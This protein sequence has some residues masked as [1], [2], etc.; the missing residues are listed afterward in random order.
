MREPALR[1]LNARTAWFALLLLLALASAAIG[2]LFAL[3]YSQDLQWDEARLFLDG[4]NPYLLYFEPGRDRPDYII[5][6]HLGLTQ[7][8]SAVLLFAPIA[9]TSF[10]TARILW[11]LVNFAATPAF[12]LLSVRLFR[13]HRFGA[14][15]LAA[16][17]LL[18]VASMP[19]RI[20][21]G[22]GQYGL[23]A[24]TLFLAALHF[25]RER[26]L[27][28]ATL[29]S[30]LALV[31]Y[32]LVLPFFA[33][34]LD[35]K[36][37]TALVL[38]GAF[39]IHLLLTVAAGHLV[40][41]RP[42]VLIR[43]S[44]TIAA[45]I[46]EAGAYDLFA[47]QARLAPE[48]GR[49]LPM[50][51]SALL[52]ALTVAMCGKEVGSRE[53]AALSIVSIVIVYHRSYDAIVLMFL[54]LHLHELRTHPSGARP[55]ALDRA[56]FHLGCAILIYVFALDQFVYGLLGSAAHATISAVFSA[57]LY[58]YLGLLFFRSFSERRAI[59]TAA[60]PVA[61]KP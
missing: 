30:T 56:E 10:E 11:I 27:A 61:A 40:D 3:D 22:N 18:F 50:A 54:V 33:L 47:F 14:F 48:L 53:L 17:T 51:L 26:R 2:T 16:L 42:D 21:I 45:S 20:T 59:S 15:G 58:G 28:L 24:M 5:P 29:F 49:T 1:L 9:L 19:W 41:E 32:T 35:R 55:G 31:K 13:P 38:A 8:P 52:I 44:L 46:T 60:T 43:Q 12:V 57:L 7:M 25:H 36:K 39:L 37:D 23:V 34:F 6:E 4:L